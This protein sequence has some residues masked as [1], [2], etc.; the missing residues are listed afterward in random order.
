MFRS[1]PRAVIQMVADP[2]SSAG[3]YTI[4]SAECNDYWPYPSLGTKSVSLYLRELHCHETG[5]SM[6]RVE[7][8]P[9]QASAIG[10]IS[11]I[12]YRGS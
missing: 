6:C 12:R 4:D 9:Y 3:V 2:T 1:I 10:Y 7:S 5:W 8:Y 11:D